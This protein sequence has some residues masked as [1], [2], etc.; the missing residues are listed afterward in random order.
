MFVSPQL[1]F[2][3]LPE[4]TDIALPSLV[5]PRSFSF[6]PDDQPLSGLRLQGAASSAAVR[7]L[8]ANHD[9]Q[10]CVLY[11]STDV[12]P[13]KPKYCSRF[14]RPT[15]VRSFVLLSTQHY[16]LTHS[17]I[18]SLLSPGHQTPF[19]FLPQPYRLSPSRPPTARPYA[20]H[21]S[22]YSWRT[23]HLISTPHHHP[24]PPAPAAIWHSFSLVRLHALST[25]MMPK[26]IF[27][28]T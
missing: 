25:G 22:F 11:P 9:K 24:H 5:P 27:R 13:I 18:I 4:R 7:S 1:S 12:S 21:V 19:S 2:N 6:S 26:P 3:F 28:P 10:R 20:T 17:T 14:F 23:S 8:N 15:T 16:S